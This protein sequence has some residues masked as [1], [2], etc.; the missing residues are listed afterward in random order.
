M[1][2]GG[3]S[4]DA[5]DQILRSRSNLGVTEVFTQRSGVHPLMNP[6][7]VNF[8]E[9][10][11]S[12]QH[13]ES[14]AIVFA[15]DETGSMQKVPEQIAKNELPGFM[16]V[17][18]DLG[19]KD[20]QLLFSAVGDAHSGEEAPCQVGQFE[21]EAQRMDSWLT[22]VN[23][24][25]GGGGSGEESYELMAYFLA[26]HTS[27]DCYEKRGKKGYVIFSGD[28]YP[29]P[30]V[31]RTQVQGI[32][33]DTLEADIPVAKIFEELREKY[34]VFFVIP[35]GHGGAEVVSQWR[36]LLG[37]GV[38][39]M[40]GRGDIC[41]VSACLVAMTEGKVESLT[42]LADTFLAQGISKDRVGAIVRALTPYAE[43]LGMAG[44]APVN[45]APATT[46]HKG[47]KG[48]RSAR[49]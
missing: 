9:S 43:S 33:G 44:V 27:I 46:L 16:Q 45:M 36:R 1:G 7:G 47:V 2:Y 26:R 5:H 23:L 8:R 22:S 37:D 14:L 35:Q 42:T 34:H 48:A 32:I 41:L 10:R 3:Y 29:Y 39:Q 49:M 18:L 11:D 30:V 20:P 15:L 24:V 21:S 6:K 19:V 17:I 28:E 38:I 25:G 4:S 13:P 31:S 40:A 12:T